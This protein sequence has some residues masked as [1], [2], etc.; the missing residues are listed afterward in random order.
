L[1]VTCPCALAMATPLSVTVALGRAARLGIFVKGGDAL[2]LLAHPSRIY[3]D[4]TGTI[5]AGQT[6][7]ASWSGPPWVQ[8]LVLAA[9]AGSPHPIADGFRRAWPE[10]VVP[11]A[12]FSQHTLGGGIHAR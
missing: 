6:A 12:S 7:L 3:L 9:E 11:R 4:K 1:V 2:E 5:T 8:P 10:A